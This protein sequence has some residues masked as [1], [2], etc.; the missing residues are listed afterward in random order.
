MRLYKKIFL[1][2]MV[3]LLFPAALFAADETTGN[4]D[5]QMHWGVSPIIYQGPE[6]GVAIGGY[7]MG[8]RNVDP[9]LSQ[10]IQN[11]FD[12]MVIYT[13]KEQMIC[14]VNLKKYFWGDRAILMGTLGYVDF[15]SEFFGIG[16]DADPDHDEDFTY[17]QK[18]FTGNFLWKLA[19]NVYLG[20]YIVY[21]RYDIEDRASGGALEKGNILGYDGTTVA[22]GGFRFMLDTR[23]DNYAPQHGS[24][25]NLQ[26][27]GYRREWG[28]DQDFLQYDITYKQF[29]PVRDTSTFAFMS[30][31]KVSDGDVPFEMMPCLGGDFIMRGYYSGIYRDNDYAALQGE[32]RYPMGSRVNGVF[33]VSLGEVAPEVAQFTAEH[34][35]VAGGFGFRFQL[36]PKQKLKLR[37]DQG[38]GE[39]GT[40][41]YVNFMEA[42]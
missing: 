20:P 13:Q 17:I 4:P 9:S 19:P 38:F 18:A 31:L 14:T 8:Y 1:S 29:W 16:P 36:Y 37:L 3:V 30:F 35:K 12:T 10:M 25:L 33:F 24:V 22:G 32:Y 2:I 41:T 28:S 21:G 6:T 7:L 5:D 11:S 26:G 40:Y 27:V 23:D 34:L 39:F 42:F 15:P